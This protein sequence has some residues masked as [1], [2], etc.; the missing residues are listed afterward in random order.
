MECLKQIKQ[1][2][3]T[4][5]RAPV[6]PGAVLVESRPFLSGR[7]VAVAT[8]MSEKTVLA[9]Q[10]LPGEAGILRKSSLNLKQQTIT[11]LVAARAAIWGL[12]RILF[13]LGA[14]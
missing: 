7:G 2:Y 10:N 9:D 3:W 4:Y 1:I 12:Y 14:P 8:P 13:T 5:A 11:I 6:R